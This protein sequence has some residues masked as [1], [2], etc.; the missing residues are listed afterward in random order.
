MRRV[1]GQHSMKA[2]MHG[3]WVIT[4]DA[5][6]SVDSPHPWPRFARRSG[7]FVAPTFA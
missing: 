1:G 6:E 2:C 3:T 4:V 7:A 5:H